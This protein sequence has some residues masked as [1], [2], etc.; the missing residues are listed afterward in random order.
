MGEKKTTKKSSVKK[1][2]LAKKKNAST[3]YEPRLRTLYKQTVIPN[4]K[5][6]FQ[7]DNIMEVPKLLSIS[8]NMGV[9]D[10]KTNN[11]GLESAV[12]ELSQIT[13]QMPITTLAKKDISNFK[14][15]RGWPVGCKVTLR[16]NRMFEFLDRLIA[17]ALPRT[18]DFRGLSFKA[19]DGR[20]NYNFG[21]QEQ[22]I[23]TEINYD[24]I[25]SIRGLNITIVSTA[26][27]DEEAYWLLKGLGL[28]L[29]EKPIK[30]EMEEAA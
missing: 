22:I 13:G 24:H 23:F 14:I 10:G 4:L 26:N 21:I 16:A 27:T 15:R 19:F 1:P 3:S 11:K 18:R 25:E 12:T 7:Y 5:S 8:L 9:G 29:R 17:V 2:S 30:Q 20:G 6:R 28:P